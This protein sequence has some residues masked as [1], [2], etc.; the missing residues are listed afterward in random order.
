MTDTTSTTQETRPPAA[1]WQRIFALVYD[2]S[3]WFGEIVGMRGRRRA[4]LSN[5]RGRVVEIGAGTGLNIAHYPDA[6]TELILTEPDAA[7]RRRLAH[8]VQRRNRVA[9]IMDAPADRLPRQ[10]GRDRQPGTTGEELLL[11][12]CCFL[13]GSFLS[14]DIFYYFNRG[15]GF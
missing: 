3:L 6:I 4:L 10:Q 11:L 1:G 9:R 7:M 12:L 8:R 15:W 13:F 5:A 2:P 14:F